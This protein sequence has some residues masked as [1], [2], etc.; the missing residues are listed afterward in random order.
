MLIFLSQKKYESI[1]S[2]ANFLFGEEDSYE[3]R[4]WIIKEYKQR[5]GEITLIKD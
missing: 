4:I 5:N 1:V 2:N 3:K